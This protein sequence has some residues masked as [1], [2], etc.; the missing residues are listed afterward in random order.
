MNLQQIQSVYFIG[1]GGIGM[2][3]LARY[4]LAKGIHVAGYDRT[5]SALTEQLIREGAAIHYTDNVQLI[6]EPF[7]QPAQ[8]LIVYTPAVPEE[9]TELAFFRAHRFE[10]LKRSQ[11]LGL[12]TRSTQSLCIAGTHGKTTVSSMTAHV[13]KQ[14]HVDCSAFLGG[15]L[16]NYQ[17]NLL[18]SAHSPFTVIEADE[19]DR[20]FH[21][22]TPYMAVITSADPDHLDIY[23][24]PKAYREGFEY[25]TSLIAPGG[26]LI[27][28]S[29]VAITPQLQAGVKL[30]TY[31]G[32]DRK[33]DFHTRNIRIGNG[34][35]F[36]DWWGPSVQITGIQLGVPVEINI[37]NAVAAIALAWL[38]GA[39]PEE[40]RDAMKT[41][42][43]AERRFDLRLKKDS[44][45]LIDDYAHHPEELRNSILSVKK[46]YADRK[47]TGIFQPHLYTRTRDFAEA[48]AESL[49]LVD[50]LILLPIYPA[51]EEP[52]PGVSSQIILDQVT[53]PD[54]KLCTKAQLLEIVAAGTYEIIL[55]LGAGDIDRLVEPIQKIMENK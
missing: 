10:V 33:A 34:K 38:N 6:P 23:G 49:S 46:L 2:S 54:K 15:I 17:N 50:E 29:G 36:F 26:A 41:F 28:K 42:A 51:R 32:S 55:I 43:G 39:F 19:Y 4:F 37:E 53:I 12:I 3:A 47:I 1:V 20:S 18:L 16:K 14:S 13:L 31:S 8:T 52:I 9:H 40:I 11:A 27:L 21:Q 7:K 24:T 44:V 22:L 48:F 35:I 25:F 5:P 30:Y 45:V